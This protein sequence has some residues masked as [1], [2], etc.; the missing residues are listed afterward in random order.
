MKY[1]P[2]KNFVRI[3]SLAIYITIAHEKGKNTD[4][5]YFNVKVSVINNNEGK[6][7]T[8]LNDRKF[9]VLTFKTTVATKQR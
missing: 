1:M 5:E 3:L 9:E 4:C 6:C 8:L 2:L 7:I